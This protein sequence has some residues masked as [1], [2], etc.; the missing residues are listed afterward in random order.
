MAI[1]QRVSKNTLIMAVAET[2]YIHIVDRKLKPIFQIW[3]TFKKMF[4]ILEKKYTQSLH[5][6]SDPNIDISLS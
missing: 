4:F 2:M 6:R 1:N 3:K 5:D